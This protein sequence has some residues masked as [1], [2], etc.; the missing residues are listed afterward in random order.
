[1]NPEDQSEWSGPLKCRA[2][3]VGRRQRRAL[4]SAQKR[5]R[6]IYRRGVTSGTDTDVDRCVRQIAAGLHQQ[7]D[8]LTAIIQRLLEEEV[9]E[10]ALDAQSIELLGAS[11]GGNVDTVL[12]AMRYE[13]AVQRVEAPTAAMEYARRLAQHGVPVHG[14][15]RAYRVGQRRMNELVFAEIQATDMDP[16][17][18]L[19]VLEK[20]SATMFAYIDWMSQQV[21]EVYEEERE[22]WLEN[23]NSLR[24]LRVHE[25]L[26]AKTPVDVD[27]ASSTIRYPLR[28]H[29][30]AVVAWYPNAGCDGNELPRLQRFLREMGQAAGAASTPLFV[31]ANAVSAWGWLPFRDAAPEAVDKARQFAATHADSPSVGIGSMAAGVGGFRRSHRRALAARAVG[32]AREPPQPTVV[33]ADDPGVLVAAMLGA[34]ITDAREWVAEVLGELAVDNEN[35]ARLRETWLV[36]LTSDGG[37][38]LAA[39]RL[40]VHSNTVKYRVGRAMARRGRAIGADRLDVELALLLC[41]WYGSL[42]TQQRPG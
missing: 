12:H 14:L 42:V 8:E 33:A 32:A 17:V 11:V 39:E 31:A 20:M 21:V 27:A 22:R 15:V 18:R 41:H 9:P 5:V 3:F 23:Q 7:L 13:I 4:I 1:M 29:H 19:A 36:F 40:N 16:V 37:Y 35:D 24:A 2:P 28:W 10:L 25:I 38:K 30:L 6:K 26:A 34:D